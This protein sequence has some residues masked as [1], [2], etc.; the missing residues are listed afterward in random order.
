MRA[1]PIPDDE[2]LPDHVRIVIGPPDG[3]DDILSSP[4]D[5]I[6][7]IV[8]PDSI[9]GPVFRTRWIPTPREIERLSAGEPLWVSQFGT[10]M[11]VMDVH[12][13]EE[14]PAL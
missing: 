10:G 5:P 12:M 3:F 7:A 13:T 14:T 2:V 9:L 8:R 4:I 1:T 11:N 6:E